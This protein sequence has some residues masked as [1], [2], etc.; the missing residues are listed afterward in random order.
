MGFGGRFTKPKAKLSLKTEKLELFLGVHAKGFA[1]FTSEE[2]FD[3]ERITIGLNYLESLK[4][5][6]MVFDTDDEG[7]SARK[8]AWILVIIGF[9]LAMIGYGGLVTLKAVDKFALIGTVGLALMFFGWL[10][11]RAN[12]RYEPK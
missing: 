6:R 12:V 8:L 3:I 10:L 9:I 5:T 7:K 11:W 2:K 4:K 1:E